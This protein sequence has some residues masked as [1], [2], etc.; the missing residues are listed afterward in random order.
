MGLAGFAKRFE[1]VSTKSNVGGIP[2][3]AFWHPP[4]L[5]IRPMS[6]VIVFI[7][8]SARPVWPEPSK[9]FEIVFCLFCFV[10]ECIGQKPGY[11]VLEGPRKPLPA[12]PAQTSGVNGVGIRPSRTTSPA[13]LLRDGDLMPFSMTVIV[14]YAPPPSPSL[15]VRNPSSPSLLPNS[16]N[17]EQDPR[18]AT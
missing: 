16:S 2:H 7:G 18:V 5:F 12:D 4:R 10:H 13:S 3:G 6:H 14:F 9:L 1:F 8:L 11:E 15:S 17:F